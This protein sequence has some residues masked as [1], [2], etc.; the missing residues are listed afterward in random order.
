M[1]NHLIHVPERWLDMLGMGPAVY[2]SYLCKIRH[3]NK[4]K[5][6]TFYPPTMG[7]Q[8]ADLG[9]NKHAI[10]RFKDELINKGIITINMKG[11]PARQLYHIRI[12]QML[13]VDKHVYNGSYTNTNYKR[14]CE[15]KINKAG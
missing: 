3:F 10:K 14:P 1:H 5:D 8:A 15:I 12:P 4:R 11:M 13:K 9:V 6:G 7:C 2:L